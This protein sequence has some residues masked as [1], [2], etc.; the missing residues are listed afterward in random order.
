MPRTEVDPQLDEMLEQYGYIRMKDNE[1]GAVYALGSDRAYVSGARFYL[2]HNGNV[3]SWE[4]EYAVKLGLQVM[5]RLCNVKQS[6]IFG[7]YPQRKP[8]ENTNYEFPHM[9]PM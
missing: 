3:R 4:C 9:R 7:R 6:P 2:V 1:V 8:E 5:E